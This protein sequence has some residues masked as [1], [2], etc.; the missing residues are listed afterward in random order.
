MHPCMSTNCT[1]VCTNIHAF[2]MNPPLHACA[3][4]ITHDAM[5]HNPPLLPIQPHRPLS[6]HTSSSP[7]VW[8]SDSIRWTAAGLICLSGSWTG[9]IL[10]KSA[11]SSILITTILGKKLKLIQ[12]HGSHCCRVNSG[13][14]AASPGFISCL[15][16]GAICR[17]QPPT[18][19]AFINL[20]EI[21][22]FSLSQPCRS[23]HVYEFSWKAQT[24]H[25]LVLFLDRA[26]THSMTWHSGNTSL[27]RVSVFYLQF[28]GKFRYNFLNAAVNDK[29]MSKGNGNHS[30][31]FLKLWIW[32]LS[33]QTLSICL[34]VLIKF[35]FMI[36]NSWVGGWNINLWKQ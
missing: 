13:Q 30:K 5:Y 25:T 7:S 8:G 28:P 36:S 31:L 6:V 23:A 24:L 18:L 32:L 11:H 15:W 19:C 2:D 20:A 22:W 29:E 12:E 16:A 35:A 10:D 34:V 4:Y 14:A 26:D 3:V 9:L 21:M 33:C 17:K 1:H 27:C